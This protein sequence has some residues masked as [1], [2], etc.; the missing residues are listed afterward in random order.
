M[1]PAF[2][3]MVTS[4]VKA[5]KLINAMYHFFKDDLDDDMRANLISMMAELDET[6]GNWS[7][8]IENDYK[9]KEG[10]G[11]EKGIVSKEIGG[12]DS[13]EPNRPSKPYPKDPGYKGETQGA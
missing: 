7:R 5:N 8:Y 6:I 3:G 4:L 10:S 12:Q 9:T 13:V 2:P 1:R 11:A